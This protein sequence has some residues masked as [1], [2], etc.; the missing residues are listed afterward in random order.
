M[1]LPSEPPSIPFSVLIA[2]G[3]FAA[4]EAALTLRELAGAAISV[5][6]LT[7]ETNLLFR[8]LGIRP[9]FAGEPA[10]TLDL[11]ELVAATGASLVA[12]RLERVNVE[13]RTVTTDDEV[14]LP[15][16]ALLLAVGSTLRPTHSSA[17]MVDPD[18]SAAL[19]DGLADGSIRSATFVVPPRAAWP[20]DL[21]E[22][23][24]TAAERIKD[25]PDTELTLVT[26]ESA[27]LAAFG[28]TISADLQARLEALGVALFVSSQAAVPSPALVE[29][30]R[31]GTT[32]PVISDAV[33]SLPEV[34]G[35]ET[36]GVPRDQYGFLPVDRFGRVRRSDRVFAAGDAAD[37]L[38]KLGGIAAEQAH[39][40]CHGIAALAGIEIKPAPFVARPSDETPRLEAFLA[41]RR[42][43]PTT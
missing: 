2:G 6:V 27:P 33:F 24:L 10:V 7:P 28:K 36:P 17:R 30:S 3:G 21:Y 23:V 4:L 31:G 12:G 40:V 37:G 43:L 38:Y 20:L 22:L 32:T 8:P 1:T 25:T 18:E 15:F 14:E 39:A 9:P 19:L 29:V 11:P 16:D 34:R 41:A 26:A 13:D 35:P 5:T 42:A